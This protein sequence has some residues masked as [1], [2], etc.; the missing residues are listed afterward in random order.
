VR[1][2]LRIKGAR[3]TVSTYEEERDYSLEVEDAFARFR[4]GEVDDHLVEIADPGSI[5]H[6]DVRP[7]RCARAP[8]PAC[9]HTSSARKTRR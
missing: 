8:A 2:T 4:Q 3:V 7:A 6:V 9:T 1:Y 5:G